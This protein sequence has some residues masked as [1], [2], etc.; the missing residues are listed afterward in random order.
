M[1][2]ITKI[3]W[4]DHTFNPW[5]G[6]TKVSDGC[7]HCYAWGMDRRFQKTPH[8]GRGV[9]RMRTRE[10]NWSQVLKWDSKSAVANAQLDFGAEPNAP[11]MRRP[12]VFCGSMCDWMD[13]EVPVEW[14][15][16]LLTLI[17]QTPS[18]DWLLLTKRPYN[19]RH[20]ISNAAIITHET[21][22]CVFMAKWMQGMPPPNVWIGAS[23]ENQKEA[24]KRIDAIQHIPARIRFLSCEPLLEKIDLAPLFSF[25]EK[26]ERVGLRRGADVVNWV[27]AGPENGVYKRKC[28]PAWIK[29]LADVCGQ[30]GIAFF[31][32]RSPELPGFTR[33]EYPGVK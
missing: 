18:L 27:I 14:L 7:K 8:W 2:E 5:Q 4:C 11:T 16:D 10:E 22:P 17:S 26:G 15:A 3:E 31:D 33:R 30:N 12:R 6:C 21:A 24:E 1:S 9:P 20:R 28:D 25:Y 23:A 32:K 29:E 13:E 19:W